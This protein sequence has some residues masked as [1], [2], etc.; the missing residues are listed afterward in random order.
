VLRRMGIDTNVQIDVSPGMRKY[1]EHHRG[2]MA[3]KQGAYQKGVAAI[4][5]QIIYPPTPQLQIHS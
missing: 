2:K 4:Q 3:R 1:L 5:P